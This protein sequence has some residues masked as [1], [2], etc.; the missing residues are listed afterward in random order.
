MHHANIDPASIEIEDNDYDNILLPPLSTGM[1][2]IMKETRSTQ[3][4]KASLQKVRTRKCKFCSFGERTD[5]K[6][7]IARNMFADD[8]KSFLEDAKVTDDDI[9]TIV[10]GIS[11]VFI[12]RAPEEVLLQD[13][14]SRE[15]LYNGSASCELVL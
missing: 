2:E 14:Q 13:T 7:E 1:V 15:Y 11:R 4:I 3:K 6:R 10:D 12:C 9:D 8:W 5:E